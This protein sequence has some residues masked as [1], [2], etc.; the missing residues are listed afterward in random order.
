MM[1]IIGIVQLAAVLSSA[2]SPVTGDFDGD[3]ATDSATVISKSDGG[4]EAIVT[5]GHGRS[6]FVSRVGEQAELAVV[7]PDRIATLCHPIERD[8]PDCTRQV[9]GRDRPGLWIK[10]ISGP[11]VQGLAV[12][13]GARFRVVESLWPE[14]AYNVEP[15]VS[16]AIHAPM[17]GKHTASRLRTVVQL[18][19]SAVG[20]AE[21][22]RVV[23]PSGAPELDTKACSI[24]MAK[25]KSTPGKRSTKPTEIVWRGNN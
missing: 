24:M 7:A 1:S 5:F 18:D 2:T 3:G 10:R 9:G 15:R 22:C 6:A 25:A 21:G 17:E 8:V 4:R 19:F 16:K 12:W 13:N 23:E 14:D 20:K 11:T